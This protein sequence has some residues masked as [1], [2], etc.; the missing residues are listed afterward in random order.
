MDPSYS[1]GLPFRNPLTS[2]TTT[3]SH[4]QAREDPIV[5]LATIP[6]SDPAHSAAIIFLH[7]LND[8]A[9]GWLSMAEQADHAT[10]A[11]AN[12]YA[13]IA[14]QFQSGKKLPYMQWI[15][16]NAKENRD[17]M[18]RAW[19]TPT[20]LSPV[21]P[22]RP[23]LKDDE[24]ESGMQESVK[25]V[26][27]LID[28]LCSKGIP[29]NRIVLG[30]FSQGCAMS[31]LTELTSQYS[32][33]LA[34]IVGL[35]GYLPLPDR[36][37]QLR[38]EAELSHIVGHTEIFLGRGQQDRLVPRSKWEEGLSKLRELGVPEA[39]MEVHEYQGLGH[40][41]SAEVLRDLC[42][43]LERVVPQLED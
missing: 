35:M 23:E 15:F 14:E 30:G 36:I 12:V 33:R 25:Y 31:L 41:L 29:P 8:D 26:V 38:T 40:A 20:S 21:Q 6:P 7:G 24:D 22:S 11:G 17:A 39:A 18:Q 37:Q 5:K 16:P 32:G 27:S 28:D 4:T 42:T 43:W 9:N 10:S 3:M 1:Y 34:G 13:D 19:Y 2:T